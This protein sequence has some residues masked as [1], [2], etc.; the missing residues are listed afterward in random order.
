MASPKTREQELRNA[1]G[2]ARLPFAAR[3]VVVRLIDRADHGTAVIPD[4]FQFKRGL[5]E[6]G[7]WC[8][9]PK[10]TLTDALRCAEFHGWIVRWRWQIVPGFEPQRVTGPAATTSGGRNRPTFYAV[11]VGNDCPGRGCPCTKKQSGSRTVPASQTGRDPDSSQAKTVRISRRKLSGAFQETAG[12][13][14]VSLEGDKEGELVEGSTNDQGRAADLRSVRVLGD[15]FGEVEILNDDDLAREW[16]Q[17]LRVQQRF[18][19]HP[20]ARPPAAIV[21]AWMFSAWW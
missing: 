21:A 3:W 5:D 1:V 9:M 6:L 15:A 7:A 8:V 20:I 10:S 17:Q 19:L 2:R 4:Q 16:Q 14:P 12:Q 13:S 11:Q 18:V